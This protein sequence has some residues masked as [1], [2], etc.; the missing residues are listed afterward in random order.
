[1]QDVESPVCRRI[2]RDS[3]A[4]FVEGLESINPGKSQKQSSL[5]GSSRLSK[6]PQTPVIALP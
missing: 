6:A 5:R 3:S 1:M 2:P 4:L